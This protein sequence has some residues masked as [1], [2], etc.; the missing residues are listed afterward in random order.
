MVK[1]RDRFADMLDRLSGTYPNDER[2]SRIN[3]K[4]FALCGLFYIAALIL[5]A[6]Y[7]LLFGLSF[8]RVNGVS[9]NDAK[10]DHVILAAMMI[11]MIAITAK[12]RNK[13][14]PAQNR[15][16][17]KT[18]LTELPRAAAELLSGT[19]DERTVHAYERGFAVCSLI[20]FA[21][22]GICFIFMIW[23]HYWQ[24]TLLLLIAAPVL[25]GIVKMRENIL[26]PPRLAHIKLNTKH[27]LLRLPVYI[28]AVLPYMFFITFVINGR[29]DYDGKIYSTNL[30]IMFLQV[31]GDTFVKW[32]HSPG[33]L[34]GF[35]LFW[36]AVI[37]IA[38]LLFHEF[39]V[40]FYCS[41]MR[42]MDA[43]ENDIS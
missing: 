19:E 34:P 25:I 40:H 14:N 42:R 3:E 28:L 1:H 5:R 33:P 43:E 2:T 10:S 7:G 27:L 9:L 41:Q 38:V 36:S 32:L 18:H 30:F 4:G 12:Q 8:R 23:N 6:I 37:Y 26:T 39:L 21:Y 31:L 16:H 15:T 11:I 35:C 13:E 22:F 29:V 24:S 17:K 20:G